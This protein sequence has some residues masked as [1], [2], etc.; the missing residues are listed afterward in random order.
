[1]SRVAVLGLGEAGAIYAA[2][3]LTAGHEVVGF[4]PAH[5]CPPPGV[6]SAASAA[7]AAQQA[8]FVLVLTGAAAAPVVAGE[9]LPV[10]KPNAIYIDL[11]SSAPGVM[12]ELAAGAADGAFVDAAIL[13]P[14]VFGRERTPVIV[15]GP[16]SAAAGELLA[17]LGAKVTDVAGRPG[18]ATA[19]K[20]IRSVAGKGLAAVVC[21]AMTAARAAG[22]ADWM[23]DELAALLPGD[24]YALIERYETGSRKH[25][26]RRAHEMD[27]VVA[28]LGELEVPSDLSR[29]SATLLHRYADEE[30]QR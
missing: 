5:P 3:L 27:D 29:A 17:G 9:C 25:A 23:R 1:M 21:E 8:D 10:L 7:E 2:G 14:V 30:T 4:D 18:D 28:Y 24:G 12:A 22:I 16:R 13:G 19:R 20:L 26:V 15:S 11:T 6:E